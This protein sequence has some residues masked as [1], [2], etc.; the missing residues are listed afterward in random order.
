MSTP[1]CPTPKLTED[2]VCKACLKGIDKLMEK[3]VKVKKASKNKR[4]RGFRVLCPESGK[5]FYIP[6]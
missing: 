3:A 5:T 4:P 1:C 2:G 6:G